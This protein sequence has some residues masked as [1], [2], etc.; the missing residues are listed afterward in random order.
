MDFSLNFSK[1]SS[2]K[3]AAERHNSAHFYHYTKNI[4][5]K[6]KKNTTI[7]KRAGGVNAP[8]LRATR[9]CENTKIP[10]GMQ[11][12]DFWSFRYAPERKK[13][14]MT[15]IKEGNDILFKVKFSNMINKMVIISHF[16]RG[17]NLSRPMLERPTLSISKFC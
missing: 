14:K 1:T 8:R 3:I 12:P 16:L 6:I 17:L 7:S 13:Q 2:G 5:V 10:A 11:K 9:T 15:K 4:S